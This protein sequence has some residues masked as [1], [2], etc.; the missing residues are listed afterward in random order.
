MKR[1]ADTT[2]PSTGQPSPTAIT[3]T[4]V[5]NLILGC[6]PQIPQRRESTRQ[7]KKPKMDLP[8]EEPYTRV[9][10]PPSFIF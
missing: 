9:S 6:Q 1:Q 3:M 7:V 4:G 2:T 8:G 10:A 5:P